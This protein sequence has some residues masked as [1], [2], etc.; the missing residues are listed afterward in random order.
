MTAHIYLVELHT[1]AGHEWRFRF[2]DDGIFG[3]HEVV[4]DYVADGD[5]TL[6]QALFILRGAWSVWSA[7]Q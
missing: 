3:M 2:D 5:L 1:D 4:C 6:E 7:R